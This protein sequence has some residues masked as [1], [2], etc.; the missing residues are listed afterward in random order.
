MRLELGPLA[1]VAPDSA[2]RFDIDDYRVAVIRFGD[3]LYAIGDECSHADYSLAEGELEPDDC[4]VE[5][6]KH[7]ALFNVATGEPESLPAVRPVPT[8]GIEVVDGVMWLIDGAEEA[9]NE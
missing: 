3:D 4:T 5:C 8:Y 9:T 2:K 6:P 1:D 7:G